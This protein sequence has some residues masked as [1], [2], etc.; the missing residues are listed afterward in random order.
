MQQD[1]ARKRIRR[2]KR[3]AQSAKDQRL[4]NA[5]D[6]YHFAEAFFPNPKKVPVSEVGSSSGRAATPGPKYTG[7]ARQLSEHEE[8]LD[9]RIRK[10]ILGPLARSVNQGGRTSDLD[11]KHPFN[12]LQERDRL[13][14]KAG[15]GLGHQ[16]DSDMDY[17]QWNDS[18]R[19]SKS[20][21]GDGT[22]GDSSAALE[23]LDAVLGKR[24]DLGDARPDQQEGGDASAAASPTLSNQTEI[25]ERSRWLS[26]G[27]DLDFDAGGLSERELRV[28]DAL[29]GTVR[30]SKPGLE[31]VRQRIRRRKQ[32]MEDE[33][34]SSG[35][36]GTA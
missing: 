3:R 11:F 13:R 9:A 4:R 16:V 10:D 6:L 25:E 12:I 27:V 23:G 26:S 20:V 28:R 1:E 7:R 14:S 33:E 36:S 31:V 24:Q 22:F 5:I 21:F 8:M 15:L 17:A 32:L 19:Q 2:W 30:G 18:S 34:V 35:T 29:F